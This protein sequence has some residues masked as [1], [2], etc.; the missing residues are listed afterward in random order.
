MADKFQ[1]TICIDFDGV[2]HSYEKGWQ[3][4]VIY[5]SVVPGFFEWVERVR[6]QFKLVIYSSRSKSNEGV[7]AMGAWLHE[8]RNIWIKN[9]G[10]RHPT[11]PL[12]MEFAHEKPA[13]W[14]TIDDRAIQ[15]RGDWSDSALSVESMA[16]FKPWN[17]RQQ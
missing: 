17:S 10:S 16:A 13:A 14:L 3:S 1:P 6:H 8:Q 9:G 5:G 12:E 11:E 4:G 15:F 2:I 7:I